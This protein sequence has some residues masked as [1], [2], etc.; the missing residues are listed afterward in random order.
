MNKKGIFNFR[1][2]VFDH[3]T[4][5]LAEA[6]RLKKH[7]EDY[8][9]YRPY[10]LLMSPGANEQDGDKR[11]KYR[12]E[13]IKFH[14]SGGHAKRQSIINMMR[15]G[16]APIGY[17]LP[18]HQEVRDS[19]EAAAKNEGVAVV[20]G[21]LALS[22]ATK[23]GDVY[24]DLRTFLDQEIN[25]VLNEFNNADNIAAKDKAIDELQKR[26]DAKTK[27]METKLGKPIEAEKPAVLDPKK[28]VAKVVVRGQVAS[29]PELTEDEEVLNPNVKIN[30]LRG[31]LESTTK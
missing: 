28:P 3:R 11:T 16:K 26:L 31:E 23:G 7:Y 29:E 15:Q 8:G 21:D 19:A 6:Q 17:Y 18:T 30:K 25:K 4:E 9:D 2:E 14:V 24:G 22:A 1:K 13:I 10:V 27:E 5:L 12:I 20:T